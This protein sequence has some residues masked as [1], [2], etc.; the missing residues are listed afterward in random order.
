VVDVLNATTPTRTG[1]VTSD[2]LRPIERYSDTVAIAAGYNRVES[3]DFSDPYAPYRLSA[4][5]TDALRFYA[6]GLVI[7][8]SYAYSSIMHPLGYGSL[9]I[10]DATDPAALSLL[11]V[12]GPIAEMSGNRGVDV[13]GTYAYVCSVDTDRLNV[14]DVA[15]PTLPTLVAYMTI[16]GP[17]YIR[18]RDSY[19]YLTSVGRFNVVDLSDPLAPVVVASISLPWTGEPWRLCL[20]DDYAYVTGR[21]ADSMGAVDISDPLSPVALGYIVN[22]EQLF[23]AEGIDVR[24]DWAFVSCSGEGDFSIIDVSDPYQP[25]L[26]GNKEILGPSFG[27]D[28]VIG[29]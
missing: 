13:L 28:C 25:Q 16:D 9:G 15:D 4:V 7:K 21:Y 17:F 14:V 8:N 1:N 10:V 29:R 27:K 24:G 19:A 22:E 23:V 12:L 2:E 3:F 11:G 18:I 5:V 6:R 20:L 26:V